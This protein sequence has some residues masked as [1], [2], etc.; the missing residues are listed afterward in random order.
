MASGGPRTPRAGESVSSS[1]QSISTD[2][3]EGSVRNKLRIC[4]IIID[5]QYYGEDSEVKALVEEFV[6]KPRDSPGLTVAATQE[7][8]QIAA[9]VKNKKEADAMASLL[10][11]IFPAPEYL[12][13]GV[14]H[15]ERTLNCQFR[16]GCVPMPLMAND[17]ALQVILEAAGQPKAPK[18]DATFGFG[19]SAFTPRQRTLN[20]DLSE[21]AYIGGD[22]RYPFLIAEWKAC[23]TGGSMEAENQ[24]ARAGAALVNNMRQLYSHLSS[25]ELSAKAETRI[26]A[27]T[28]CFSATV[29][30]RTVTLWLHWLQLHVQAG[31]DDD[32]DD[33]YHQMSRLKT[34]NLLEDPDERHEELRRLRRAIDNIFGWG[35]KERLP[36][37]REV[38]DDIL[39]VRGEVALKLKR[40]GPPPA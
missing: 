34:F 15:L 40:K 26:I 1:K 7:L 4:R 32:D 38:L 33:P 36:E 17:L 9:A 5:E 27:R 28:A 16:P 13:G 18:P 24:A 30:S 6:K 14:A 10:P 11:L 22:A 3:S 8:G 25:G 31:E 19:D 21:L 20:S 29:D 23:S 12:T 35:L 2:K 37:I 39:K